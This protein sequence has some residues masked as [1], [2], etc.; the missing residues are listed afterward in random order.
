MTDPLDP[1]ERA[2]VALVPLAPVVARV[3]ADVDAQV[4]K[5]A[6]R[7]AVAR[8]GWTPT[9]R[10][11]N[12]GYCRFCDAI[13]GLRAGFEPIGSVSFVSS[14]SQEASNL[15]FWQVQGWLT[16]RV[17]SEPCELA[18][19]ATEPLLARDSSP[20]DETVC[21]SWETSPSQTIRDARF[22]SV[23]R[24]TPWSISLVELLAAPGDSD[25]HA[26]TI[27]P[28]RPRTPGG[29]AVSSKRSDRVADETDVRPTD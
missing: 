1:R 2:F 10:K 20:S 7:N 14:A 3:L 22:V 25:G 17:K 11:T 28:F 21:L 8:V 18:Y 4:A 29:P 5:D 23:H 27:S 26:G 13:R 12:S 19:E 15:F 24:L 9:Q 16:V 6:T